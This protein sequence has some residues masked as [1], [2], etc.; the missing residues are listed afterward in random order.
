MKIEKLMEFLNNKEEHYTISDEFVRK[1]QQTPSNKDS[2]VY[3][4]WKLGKTI[5]K[6]KAEPNQK[7][8]FFDRY[9]KVKTDEKSISK[10]DEAEKL[11]NGIECPELLIWLAEA[12]NINKETIKIVSV[13]AEKNL[14]NGEKT[15]AQVANEIRKQIPWRMMEKTIQLEMNENIRNINVT[16][17]INEF[18]CNYRKRQ[19]IKKRDTILKAILIISAIASVLTLILG[20][21]G[22][23]NILISLIFMVALILDTNCMIYIANKESYPIYN[24]KQ[25]ESIKNMLKKKKIYNKEKRLELREVLNNRISK[26][27]KYENN[28]K[29]IFVT[30]TIPMILTYIH[31]H[32][33]CAPLWLQIVA[34]IILGLVIVAII[35]LLEIKTNQQTSSVWELICAI[36]EIE[37]RNI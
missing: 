36:D 23:W 12:C 14:E 22:V 21:L 29:F 11:Y 30:F 25:L 20:Y 26:T 15:R 37:L 10:Q 4:A 16:D 24:N 31:E 7:W 9:I 35:G 13:K 28:W 1:F 17:I 32:M 33:M 6:E 27:A 19:E 34:T 5:S 8:H 18:E 2:Y 3:Y